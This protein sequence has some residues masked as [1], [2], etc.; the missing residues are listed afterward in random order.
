M[1]IA[2]LISKHTVNNRNLLSIFLQ[3]LA[4]RYMP[5]DML[6]QKLVE[7]AAEIETIT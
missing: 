3:E 4:S 2:Y 6:H 5:D 1:T 7:L